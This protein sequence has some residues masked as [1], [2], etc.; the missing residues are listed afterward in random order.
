[1]SHS[2]INLGEIPD[3]TAEPTTTAPIIVPAEK[4]EY[5]E[6]GNPIDK[7]EEKE[8]KKEIIVKKSEGYSVGAISGNGGQI[9]DCYVTDVSVN[10]Y[11]DDYILNVGGISGEQ[12]HLT[13]L[14]ILIAL[15]ILA[16]MLLNLP[17]KQ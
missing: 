13:S 16:M 8:E 9:E 5:D 4:I 10:V 14:L 17:T 12:I 11:S 3:D 15:P 6:N 2:S 1:M 7:E